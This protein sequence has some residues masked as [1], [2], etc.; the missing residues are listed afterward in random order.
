MARAICAGACRRTDFHSRLAAG[1]LHKFLSGRMA[2]HS[3]FVV[4]ARNPRPAVAIGSGKAAFY[5]GSPPHSAP[6]AAFRRSPRNP[7]LP[8]QDVGGQKSW[9]NHALTLRCESRFIGHAFRLR[10]AERPDG[11]LQCISV[12]QRLR[13][14]V[15]LRRSCQQVS[16]DLCRAVPRVGNGTSVNRLLTPYLVFAG[17]IDAR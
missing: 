6:S 5:A 13:W 10:G 4:P 14:S 11:L 1:F 15:G 7:H 8:T 17:I 9:T 3:D 2:R 16:G 12:L